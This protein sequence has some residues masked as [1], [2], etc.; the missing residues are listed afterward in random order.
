MS[1]NKQNKGPQDL[2]S[3]R[4]DKVAHNVGNAASYKVDAFTPHA[5]GT[6]LRSLIPKTRRL[7][8]DINGVRGKRQTLPQRGRQ[9][10]PLDVIEN[11]LRETQKQ[12][13]TKTP[14]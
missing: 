9:K 10:D 3:C 6:G 14:Q 1:G 2:P 4:F 13:E 8:R 7:P 12:S 11:R 5:H